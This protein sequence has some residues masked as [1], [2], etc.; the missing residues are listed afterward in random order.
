MLDFFNFAPKTSYSTVQK[1]NKGTAIL[2]FSRKAEEEVYAKK[3]SSSL[4]SDQNR[5]LFSHLI[6]KS[7]QL[8][9]DSGLDYFHSS[10]FIDNDSRSFGLKL[11][12]AV[13]F[14]FN[15]GY[16]S[17]IIIGNDTPNLSLNQIQKAQE[18]LK[19]DINTIGPST[20]GGTYLIAFQ[21]SD[22]NTENFEALS[23]CTNE[24]N[25]ELKIELSGFGHAIKELDILGDLDNRK[26][27]DNYLVEN[28]NSSL[29]KLYQFLI[30]TYFHEEKVFK[31][32][33]FSKCANVLRGPPSHNLQSE[34]RAA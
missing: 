11:S 10:E 15:K 24:L 27:F 4:N 5:Q 22:F 1:A 23:W 34:N 17:I 20:D 14:V 13:N 31:S 26:D 30:H 6:S 8:M 3:L 29:R 25:E 19:N 16:E 18:N 7:K 12:T 21:K 33:A 2:L 9:Y 32:K 28:K